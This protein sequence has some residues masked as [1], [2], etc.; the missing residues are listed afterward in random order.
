MKN[1]LAKL[2]LICAIFCFQNNFAQSAKENIWISYYN[3]N[4]IAIKKGSIP[5][6]TPACIPIKVCTSKSEN[7]IYIESSY[8]T[9]VEYYICNSDNTPLLTG[10]FYSSASV[11]TTINIENLPNGLYDIY[12]IV[13]ESVYKGTLEI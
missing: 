2:T 7:N 6:R 12:L 3:G 8:D 1:L 13:D 5:N 10:N 11:C 9:N 4:K